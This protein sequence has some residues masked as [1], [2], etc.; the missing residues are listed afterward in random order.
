MCLDCLHFILQLA[1][2]LHWFWRRSGCASSLVGLQVA[3]VED[4]VKLMESPLQVQLVGGSSNLLGNL[5][6]SN[7]A[8]V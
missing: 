3:G 5:E 6:R 2:Q 1:F 4:W 8:G 7:P